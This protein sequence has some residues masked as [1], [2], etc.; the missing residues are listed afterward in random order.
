MGLHVSPETETKIF[1]VIGIAFAV[2]GVLFAGTEKEKAIFLLV[3]V[4]MACIPDMPPLLTRDYWEGPQSSEIRNTLGVLRVPMLIVGAGLLAYFAVPG[5]SVR[6]V[7]VWTDGNRFGLAAG[8][9]LVVF[10]LLLSGEG[11]R[12]L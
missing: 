7:A 8:A 2:G 10:G 6:G 1:R 3:G 12:R 9:V 4:V 5:D 11:R